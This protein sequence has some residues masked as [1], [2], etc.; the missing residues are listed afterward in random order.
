[1]CPCASVH[2]C[3]TSD[4]L[5][6]PSLV[7]AGSHYGASRD[8]IVRMIERMRQTIATLPVHTSTR[9]DRHSM[10]EWI[11]QA[12]HRHSV[13]GMHVAVYGST[14]PRWEAMLLA[15]GAARVTTIEYNRLTYSHEAIRT[16]TVAEYARSPE[17]FDAALSLSS[18]DH[19]GLGRYGDPVDA[20]A[21]LRAMERARCALRSGGR[22]FMTVPVGPD[23]LVWNL[24][25]RYGPL[26]LPLMLRGWTVEER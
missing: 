7:C 24:H 15:F 23:A 4:T 20:E 12:L 13:K 19:D 2:R 11:L 21:D 25:R 5:P 6:S 10:D 8:E 17:Q 22:L 9:T 3:A 14:E 26:R 18:F 16:M 1:M